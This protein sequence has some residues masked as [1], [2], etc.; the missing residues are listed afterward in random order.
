MKRRLSFAFAYALVFTTILTVTSGAARASTG[1]T[2][3]ATSAGYLFDVACVS[4]T[5]C[6]AVG[7]MG[8]TGAGTKRPLI[9][10]YDGLSWAVYPSPSI[11]VESQLSGVMCTAAS[12][13]WAVGESN[14]SVSEDLIEHFDGSSWTQVPGGVP[15]PGGG[16]AGVTCTSSIDCWAT[17]FQNNAIEHFDGTA[18]TVA[19]APALG[20]PL[21][22]LYRVRC[23]SPTDCWAVG[24]LG[25]SPPQGGLIAH[26]DGSQWSFVPEAQPA[27]D[28]AVDDVACPSAGDCWGVGCAS[29][30]A[31]AS[32][33]SYN[34]TTWSD[35]PVPNSQA[36]DELTGIAC[37][38]AATCWAAGGFGPSGSGV[39]AYGQGQIWSSSVVGFSAYAV[40]CFPSGE[41]WATGA[42]IA[43]L[44]A[45]TT[46]P[47]PSPT[48]APTPSPSPTTPTVP[49]SGL[50]TGP[51]QLVADTLV[52]SGLAL[53]IA[54]AALRRR[55]RAAKSR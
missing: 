43:H 15:V 46:P 37:P 7:A 21:Y 2:K 25:A 36:W 50:R 52:C 40:T 18:W 47:T 51:G 28:S 45:A 9:E 31:N 1:W 22:Q 32:A 34:G 53:T 49:S 41:C 3:V 11:A 13:C 17:G 29:T 39:M 8:N 14:P 10:H 6:W 19:F 44:A 33:Q 27:N 23:P 54:G 26:F 38:T 5:D 55:S 48:G 12:D 35:A 20:Q 4:T 16:L 30:C 42:D 24:R